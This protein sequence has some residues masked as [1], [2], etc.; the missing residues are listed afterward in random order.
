MDEYKAFYTVCTLPE[1]R[2]CLNLLEKKLL[3]QNIVAG[4][5]FGGKFCIYQ[6]TVRMS[7]K[8]SA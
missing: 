7:S 4:F 8:N 5:R 2:I 1:D 6:V 3:E